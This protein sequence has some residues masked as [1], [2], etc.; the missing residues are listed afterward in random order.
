MTLSPR[1]CVVTG[2]TGRIVSFTVRRPTPDGC[3]VSIP[4]IGLNKKQAETPADE[5][6]AHFRRFVIEG[7][8]EVT[9]RRYLAERK[10]AYRNAIKHSAVEFLRRAFGWAGAHP[11]HVQHD[12]DAFYAMGVPELAR[13]LTREVSAHLWFRGEAYKAGIYSIRRV[14]L[15]HLLDAARA[16]KADSMLEIGFGSGINLVSLA[17]LDPKLNL[18]GI[19]FTA[20]GVRLAQALVASPP[21]E[22]LQFLGIDRLDADQR[23]ALSR[24]RFI[25]ASATAIPLPDKSFDLVFTNQV[26]EQMGWNNLYKQAIAEARRIARK[27]AVFIECFHECNRGVQRFYLIYKN[28]FRDRWKKFADYG[29]EPVS[30]SEDVPMKFL[31]Q[32]GVLV[33]D[34]R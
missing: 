19:E 25:H 6:L 2:L 10:R 4:R 14:Q 1:Y 13:Y 18:A 29:F 23:A 12:Y 20:S 31:Y 32:A 8:S 17:I 24:I 34:V 3:A 22:L 21:P 15:V 33:C 9:R 16:V 30:F 28:Y 27:R 11:R 7:P 5:K 26:L